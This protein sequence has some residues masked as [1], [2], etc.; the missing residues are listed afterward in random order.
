MSRRKRTSNRT[1]ILLWFFV[2]TGLVIFVGCKEKNVSNK[3]SKYKLTN[4]LSALAPDKNIPAVLNTT[5][6]K[7]KKSEHSKKTD[8]LENVM[9]QLGPAK[10]ND[11]SESVGQV[12]EVSEP[13]RDFDLSAQRRMEDPGS[14]RVINLP[15]MINVF[16]PP[17]KRRFAPRPRD[18]LHVLEIPG[19]SRR[20]HENFE[21][22]PPHFNSENIPVH[23]YPNVRSPEVT[24]GKPKHLFLP[25]PREY[26][27][28]SR[29]LHR[30][31]HNH[32]IDSDIAGFHDGSN[33]A[34]FEG[35]KIPRLSPLH[36]TEYPSFPPDSG[37]PVA[38]DHLPFDHN[39]YRGDSSNVDVQ[40]SEL[41]LVNLPAPKMFSHPPKH[42]FEGG[43]EVTLDNGKEY[44]MNNELHVV[45]HGQHHHHH[46]LPDMDHYDHDDDQYVH[47]EDHDDHFHHSDY[48]DHGDVE[49][50]N[51]D[52]SYD[53]HGSP[54][55][56][57]DPEHVVHEHHSVEHHHHLGW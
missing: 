5:S 50:D 56:I 41:G 37:V 57:A 23:F 51:A 46:Q 43:K 19:L 54:I 30:G 9:S 45:E 52:D 21:I 31:S 7:A 1:D 39:E 34:G 8:I 33:G 10:Q 53:S 18:P 38:E 29:G 14:P 28:H 4:V 11:I 12:S 40:G 22:V 15:G 13:A 26:G 16:G 17:P 48:D 27:L 32:I 44:N 35:Y 2:A 49:G 25:F 47:D 6:T 42:I 55:Q 3:P 36:Q 20:S 24:G